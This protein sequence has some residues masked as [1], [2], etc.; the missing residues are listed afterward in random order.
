MTWHAFCCL[1]FSE[2]LIHL[3]LRFVGD[4]WSCAPENHLP[5]SNVKLFRRIPEGKQLCPCVFFPN[6]I[7]TRARAHQDLTHDC[8][9]LS[10]PKHECKCNYCVTRSPPAL[11]APLCFFSLDCLHCLHC[12]PHLS[13]EHIHSFTPLTVAVISHVCGFSWLQ[14]GRIKIPCVG[15]IKSPCAVTTVIRRRLG[16][17][18]AAGALSV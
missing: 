13:T 10:I 8:L 12:A 16:H 17:Q 7:T 4:D 1:L 9:P 2:I 5:E 18:A 6:T 15:R 14:L 3:Y 11:V